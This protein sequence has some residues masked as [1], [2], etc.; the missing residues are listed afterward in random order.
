ME[1]LQRGAMKQVGQKYGHLA[2][3]AALCNAENKNCQMPLKVQ[4]PSMH[5]T[6]SAL[7]RNMPYDLFSFVQQ[8]PK[9]PTKKVCAPYSL[10]LHIRS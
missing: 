7:S 10:T 8:T 4:C 3:L 6:L 5:T 1:Q 2:Q 9:D